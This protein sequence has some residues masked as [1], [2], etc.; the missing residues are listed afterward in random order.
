MKSKV[1][2][3]TFC[4][5]KT[6]NPLTFGSIEFENRK[7]NIYTI[8]FKD[9]AMV[10]AQV[11]L[12]IYTPK[13]ENLLAHQ[14]V[15]STVMKEHSVIPIS[16]GN[17][18]K[19]EEDVKVLLKKL[20]S[21][22]KQLFPQIENKIEVGLK[23]IGKKEWLKKMLEKNTSISKLKNE[24]ESKSKDAAFYDRIQ[25]GEL[26]R[27]SFKVIEEK[28]VNEVFSPLTK[29]SVASKQNDVVNERMLLNAAFLID[30][31]KE[32]E[33]DQKVNECYHQWGDKVDFK[34]SGPWP[35]YNFINIKVKVE[36]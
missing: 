28:I 24:I 27:N 31:D 12:K 25:L 15:I 13:K 7:T 29:I 23:I 36:E 21:Q 32:A 2:I 8:H 30:C 19:K 4:S 34:Y 14:T 3:Y 26:T 1:G 9:I 33:F 10:V 17:V 16:F 11:P 22:F 6:Q 18:F 20:Y 5:I 35:P